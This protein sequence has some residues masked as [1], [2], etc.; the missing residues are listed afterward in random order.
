MKLHQISN[1]FP[2]ILT[3][4][5]NRFIKTHGDQVS[6]KSLDERGVWLA[7]NL[8]RKNIYKIIE[9]NTTLILNK[10]ES[11]KTTL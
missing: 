2:I 3:N 4:E 7:Q 10:D 9:D 6:L 1:K 5:E 11:G 8:V